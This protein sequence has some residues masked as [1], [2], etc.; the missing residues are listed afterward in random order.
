M[1]R[2]LHRNLPAAFDEYRVDV[3]T[4]PRLTARYNV[5]SIPTVIVLCN[6]EE[7]GR[8]DGTSGDTDLEQIVTPPP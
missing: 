4:Q 6:G 8:L 2:T 7:T 3:G 1:P 5:M